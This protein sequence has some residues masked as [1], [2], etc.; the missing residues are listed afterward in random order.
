MNGPTRS[1]LNAFWPGSRA[2]YRQPFLIIRRSSTRRFI[3][4][5]ARYSKTLFTLSFILGLPRLCTLSRLPNDRSVHI[6]LYIG[7]IGQYLIGFG[8]AGRRVKRKRRENVTNSRQQRAFCRA[9]CIYYPV[10]GGGAR[11]QSRKLVF[12][13]VRS[14][15]CARRRARRR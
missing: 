12:Y 2:R 14:G 8:L 3:Y 5:R 1:G 7:A 6:I 11:S 9:V 15:H 13:I 10:Y 4:T